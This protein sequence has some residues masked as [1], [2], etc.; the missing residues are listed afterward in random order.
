[1]GNAFNHQTDHEHAHASSDG[2][3]HHT[4]TH[5][6][7][8]HS[9]GRLSWLG[10]LFPWLHGHSHG[11]ARVDTALES[12]ARGIR[13]LKISLVILGT[14]ALFQV[15]IFLLSGSVGL[16]A[17]TIHNF[18]DALTA[19]PLWIAFVLARRAPTRRYTYGYGRAEDV[20]GIIIVLMIFAS[21]VIAGYESIQKLAHPE[22]LRNVGWVISAALIGF[23]GNEAVAIFRI[24]V[25]REIGSAALIADGQHA[26]VDGFTSLAVLL[27]AVGSLLGF[28]LAD[29]IIGLI[30]TVAILFI[31]KDIAVTMWLRLMDAVEPE[32][33]EKAEQVAAGVPGVQQVHALRMRWLGHR[34]QA[35]MHIIVDENLPTRESHRIAEEVRHTLFH[36]HPRLSLVDIHVDPCEHNGTDHHQLTAHHNTFSLAH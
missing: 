29:P 31:V 33:V 1:V 9:H 23:I 18:S 2:D 10:G 26:R 24:R 7:H 3:H 5:H 17:D 34:L 12:S 36:T 20:A 8:D 6:D 13:A 32:L 14:T 28:P 25:G 21:A 4:H 16:L 11:E 19:I 30:I 35:E 22:P 27:G 15:A